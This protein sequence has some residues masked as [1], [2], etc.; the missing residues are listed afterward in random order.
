MSMGKVSKVSQLIPCAQN[1]EPTRFHI[2]GKLTYSS[3]FP[4]YELVCIQRQ[5]ATSNGIG[6]GDGLSQRF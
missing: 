1:I 5:D 4:L 3:T 2:D 6:F